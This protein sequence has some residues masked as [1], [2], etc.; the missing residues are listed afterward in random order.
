MKI[1]STRHGQTSFNRQDIILGITDIGLDETGIMQASVLAEKIENLGNIDIIIASPMRRAQET[2]LAIAERCGL[3][4]VT[5]EKLREWD[6][7]KYEGKD[8]MTEGFAEN[9]VNFAVKMGEYGESLLQLA[10]RVYSAL[11]DIIEKYHDKTVLLVTHGGVCRVIET[12][13]NDMTTMQFSNWF[14]DNC[15]LIEYTIE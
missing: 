9:K 8:R 6:Y 12:Y 4:I 14:M 7:G 13:F 15:G 11:D 10:H 5:D 2:A 3:S 1:Y